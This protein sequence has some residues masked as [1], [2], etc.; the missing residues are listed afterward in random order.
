MLDEIFTPLSAAPVVGAER[1][2]FLK[3]CM[4]E[5][6][7]S[8]GKLDKKRILKAA[9]KVGLQPPTGCDPKARGSATQLT[10]FAEL[11]AFEIFDQAKFAASTPGGGSASSSSSTADN[12]KR[13][14][15]YSRGGSSRKRANPTPGRKA[16]END[17]ST[18]FVIPAYHDIPIWNHV[19][20]RSEVFDSSPPRKRWVND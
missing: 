2:E 9:G 1:D 20:Y 8:A 12:P 13:M 19:H 7:L 3:K 5:T 4:E 11:V 18:L 15:G 6:F 16:C 10:D 14:L 17:S